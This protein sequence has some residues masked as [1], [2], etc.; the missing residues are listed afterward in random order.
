[1]DHEGCGLAGRI[2]IAP[3]P[4]P[5]E[6][7]HD[8]IVVGPQGEASIAQAARDSGILES[9]SAG[10][11]MADREG[12]PRRAGCAPVLAV[13]C[14]QW[15]AMQEQWKRKAGRGAD[16]RFGDLVGVGHGDDR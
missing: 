7:R 14:R 11:K 2:I 8:V 3:K 13:G 15:T 10:S 5:S 9:C 12:R 6:F 16:V 1:M 4:F